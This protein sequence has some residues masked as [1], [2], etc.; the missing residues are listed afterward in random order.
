VTVLRF[1]SD[2][3]PLLKHGSP[4]R[5]GYAALHPNG[6]TG[7]VV[8]AS[9][10][11]R[12]SR[13]RLGRG[14]SAIAVDERRLKA[15]AEAAG[16]PFSTEG[17]WMGD[18]SAARG[19]RSAGSSRALSALFSTDPEAVEL[20]RIQ[21]RADVTEYAAG[22]I[23]EQGFADPS[24]VVSREDFATLAQSG[25][26]EVIFRGGPAGIADGMT[27]GQP[28]VGTGI[29]GPGSYFAP[30]PWAAIGYAQRS[31]AEPEVMVA[32][33]PKAASRGS[34][35]S[36]RS[37]D[38]SG[39]GGVGYG[40]DTGAD[41]ILSRDINTSLMSRVVYNTGSLIV[42]AGPRTPADAVD[43]ARDLGIDVTSAE[44]MLK[45]EV[46]QD[47]D[48]WR[49]NPDGTLVH[50]WPKDVVKHGTH[51]Q[52]DHGRRGG[53][54]SVADP[55]ATTRLRAGKAVIVEGDQVAGVVAAFEGSTD[56]PVDLT[57]L[58]V[59]GR[60]LFSGDGLGIA[61]EDMPQIPKTHR[62]SFFAE[63]KARGVTVTVERVDPLTMKPTQR[64][65]DVVN[66]AGM[67]KGMRDGTFVEGSHTLI[68]SS[69]GYILDG[70]HRWAAAVVRRLET[71]EGDMGI[72]RVGLPI[73]QLLEE[74]QTFNEE[75]GIASR[76]LGDHARR[77]QKA[78]VDRA[79]TRAVLKHL[80]G[81]HDQSSHGRKGGVSTGPP[82]DRPIGMRDPGHPDEEI[83]VIPAAHNPLDGLNVVSIFKGGQQAGVLRYD[84]T[85]R[86][87]W[88]N[89]QPEFRR[90]GVAT[91]LWESAKYVADRHGNM[92]QPRHS[93][94]QTDDGKAWAAVVKFAPGLRPVLKHGSHD[95]STH[96]RRYSGTVDPAV[97][98]KAIRLVGENGG[99]SI[100]MTDGSEPT[101]GYMVARNS[102]RFGLAVTAD[103][104]YG[105]QGAKAIA[106]IVKKNRVALGSGRAH[107]GIWHQ[108]E[109]THP[110]G[111]T[112]P[113]ARK[114]QVVHLDVTDNIPVRDRALR[115]GRRRNQISVWDVVEFEE[116][117]T[118]G[119]GAEVAKG[120]D[121]RGDT[122]AAVGDDGRGDRRVGEAGPRA[123]GGAGLG[124]PLLK[125]GS[126]DRPGYAA[127]HP[128]SKGAS[129]AVPA[130]WSK[131]SKDDQIA[132]IATEAE[133]WAASPEKAREFAT[134][135]AAGLDIYDGPN[136][137][138]IEVAT[139]HDLP[140][141]VIAAQM[142]AVGDLQAIAPVPGLKVVISDGVF[143]ARGLPE[144]TKGFVGSGEPTTINLRPTA[145]TTGVNTHSGRLMPVLGADA[146]LY[147]VTHEYGHVLDRRSREVSDRDKAD[148]VSRHQTGMSRYAFDDDPDGEPGREA[149]AEAWVGWVG[150]QGRMAGPDSE[151]GNAFVRY[152]A[153]TYGWDAGSATT[154]P[155]AGF[156]KAGPAGVII[157]ADT[158]TD[159][160]S[161]TIRVDGIHKHADH[162]QKDHG[163][164]YSRGVITSEL[165][166]EE[167][168]AIYRAMGLD[169]APNVGESL[170]LRRIGQAAGRA[171]RRIRELAQRRGLIRPEPYRE[172]L[173]QR[174]KLQQHYEAMHG[175]RRRYPGGS[176]LRPA[177]VRDAA[178]DWR[179]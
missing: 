108:K 133:S 140:E 84:D 82:L 164:R 83:T 85:G 110:D 16:R 64:E 127:L 76:A 65:M 69:D 33:L 144:S 71:G 73:R 42:A 72:A 75:H 96:G 95:Q 105:P 155:S 19:I 136:G 103:T 113:L 27:S 3:R 171:Q 11:D 177:H 12:I 173:E 32:L 123:D 45:A 50:V 129:T 153:E 48:L 122:E 154:P 151:G 90:Q 167:K 118:G 102:T 59:A 121:R 97:A 5:P 40:V 41:Y 2:L 175:P 112:T 145:V 119:T 30:A 100:R 116:L 159:E 43:L 36:S 94:T 60:G 161:I 111:S 149:F 109:I 25:D 9:E 157:I 67:A 152:Y 22:R 70:H 80:A 104:F 38:R 91:R 134:I 53:R 18:L 126:P 87:D 26:Y 150:S 35:R 51:N 7:G 77:V 93:D 115:L 160:G 29:G 4:D 17:D 24:P 58:H 57:N 158:F 92:P 62:D 8:S 179:G 63:Q 147:A 68:A 178:G 54:A 170:L 20:Y 176:D 142:R 168:R 137:T 98:A 135:V 166:E 156:A 15:A 117:P 132:A 52:K 34:D 61:R 141:S 21:D 172:T 169:Y 165:I 125:H 101:S 55:T 56:G 81:K 99:L 130:G 107:L 37:S 74:A 46:E 163:R 10:A 47:A 23:R 139:T 106:D 31:G 6:A 89:V 39:L 28:W 148:V 120:T 114:D 162:N 128:G 124:R 138:T 78:A 13:S 88:V 44:R 79:E 174:I 66:V 1:E 131:R 146:H 86:V 143:T 14:T 49:I